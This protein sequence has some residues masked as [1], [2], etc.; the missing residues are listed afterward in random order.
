MAQ[1]TIGEGLWSTIRGYLNAMFTELYAS[2]GS[3]GVGDSMK[4]SQTINLTAGVETRVTTTLTTEPYSV[5][6]LD[7]SGSI[8]GPHLIDM[9]MSLVGGVYVFDIYSADALSN[10]KLK[11]I[12]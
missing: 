7:A 9:Q 3:G 10:A 5:M 6:V 2:L 12:Y 11:I 4:Y 8:I 1:I